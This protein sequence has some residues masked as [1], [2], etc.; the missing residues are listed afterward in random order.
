MI[1]T[2]DSFKVNSFKERSLLHCYQIS[3]I[4]ISAKTCNNVQFV[5]RLSYGNLSVIPSACR[6]SSKS[7]TL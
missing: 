3:L 5:S 7:V 6:H 1:N 2:S 4:T